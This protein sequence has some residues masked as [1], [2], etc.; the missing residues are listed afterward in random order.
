[1]HAAFDWQVF[2]KCLIIKCIAIFMKFIIFGAI[3]LES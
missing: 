2:G 3:L 1:M